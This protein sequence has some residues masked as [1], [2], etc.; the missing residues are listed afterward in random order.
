MH[1]QMRNSYNRIPMGDNAHQLF[2]QQPTFLYQQ[3]PLVNSLDLSLN[4]IKGHPEHVHIRPNMKKRPLYDNQEDQG[5][6]DYYPSPDP[7]K[8]GKLLHSA[9]ATT[10]MNNSEYSANKLPRVDANYLYTQTPLPLSPQSPFL[11]NVMPSRYSQ[12]IPKFDLA[13][14]CDDLK[15]SP[16]TFYDLKYSPAQLLH[17]STSSVPKEPSPLFFKPTTIPKKP[18]ATKKVQSSPQPVLELPHKI[19]SDN[20]KQSWELIKSIGRGGCGE[21]YLAR[22]LIIEPSPFVAIKIIKVH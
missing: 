11:P 16:G 22:E 2:Y 5:M 4:P 14:S 13:G 1:L 21:V 9:F 15:F 7:P 3:T 8:K 6:I 10:P 19:E 20:G 18:A 17:K 12:L